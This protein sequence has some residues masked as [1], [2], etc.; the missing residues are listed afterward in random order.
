[1]EAEEV[2]FGVGFADGVAEHNRAE[3]VVDA[4]APQKMTKAQFR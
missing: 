1:M 4:V 3:E 2:V